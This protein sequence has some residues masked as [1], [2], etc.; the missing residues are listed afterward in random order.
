MEYLNFL[1]FIFYYFFCGGR[2]FEEQEQ[3]SLYM[4]NC[5]QTKISNGLCT[6]LHQEMDFDFSPFHSSIYTVFKLKKEQR[7]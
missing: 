1:F 2:I 6:F 7:I 5:Q 4:R 3:K